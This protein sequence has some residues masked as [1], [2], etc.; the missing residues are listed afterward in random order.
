MS[1]N[2][3]F[4]KKPISLERAEQLAKQIRLLEN[5]KQQVGSTGMKDFSASIKNESTVPNRLRDGG[6]VKASLILI[7]SQRLEV[8]YFDLYIQCL[9]PN[10][11][12]TVQT[13]ELRQ[14]LKEKD[15]EILHMQSQIIQRD[16]RIASLESMVEKALRR[17]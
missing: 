9:P 6:D 7:L 2:S 10:L 13:R 14:A 5:V 1:S 3:S 4:G 15:D 12:E 17:G 11:R 16:E 8:N